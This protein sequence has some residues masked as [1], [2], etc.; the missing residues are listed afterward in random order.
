MLVTRSTEPGHLPSEIAPIGS[1][2]TCTLS[3]DRILAAVLC[4]ASISV[5]ATRHAV[6]AVDFDHSGSSASAAFQPRS[7]CPDSSLPIPAKIAFQ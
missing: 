6:G 3:A 2:P 7:R 4:R 1:S 5:L